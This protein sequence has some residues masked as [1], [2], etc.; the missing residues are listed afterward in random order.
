MEERKRLTDEEF[1]QLVNNNTVT[2]PASLLLF[3]IRFM[4]MV[5]SRS[6]VVKPGEMVNI[7]T[8]YEYSSKVI[9][10]LVEKY[11]TNIMESIPE[12]ETKKKKKKKPK[13][14]FKLIN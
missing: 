8:N 9:H 7:G 12:E 1:Q 11:H 14:Q 6:G 5:T 2:I 10:N 13:K 3:H 4:E